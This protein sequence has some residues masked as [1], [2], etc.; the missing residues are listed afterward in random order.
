LLSCF[1]S[2]CAVGTRL[3]ASRQDFQL[4]R[5]TRLA[6]TVEDR[7]GASHRYLKLEPEGKWNSEGRSWFK[8]AE[9]GYYKASRD[10]LPRLRAYLLAMPDGPHS[11]A[12]TSRLVELETEMGFAV[13]REQRSLAAA[14]KVQSNLE[15][16]AEQRRGFVRGI[17]T[18][19]KLLGAIETWGEP[20]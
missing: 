7:L 2:G 9:P 14:R 15:L 13:A 3:S 17:A 19:L 11:A 12:V 8:L 1:A 4:Y 20:T 10:S 6:A 18:W 16:A 5:E